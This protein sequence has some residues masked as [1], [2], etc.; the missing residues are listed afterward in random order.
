MTAETDAPTWFV[1]TAGSIMVFLC[2]V[3]MVLALLTAPAKVTGA[4]VLGAMLGY[5]LARPLILLMQAWP[6]RQRPV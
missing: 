4:V 3:V 6:R 2:I 1:W 5:L